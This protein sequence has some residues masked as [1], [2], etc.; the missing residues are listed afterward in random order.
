[1]VLYG[2]QK[3]QDRH[4][5]KNDITKLYLDRNQIEEMAFSIRFLAWRTSDKKEAEKMLAKVKKAYVGTRYRFD[6]VEIL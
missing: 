2:I 5:K 1:M 4:E 3:R 6:V